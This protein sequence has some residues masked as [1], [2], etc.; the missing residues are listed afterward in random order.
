MRMPQVDWLGQKAQID[1]ARGAGVKKVVLISSMGVTDE[2]NPLN[3]LGDGN[4]LVWK[5]RAEVCTAHCAGPD[6]LH[7]RVQDHRKSC[8]PVGV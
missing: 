6:M 8:W 1:A 5:R 4:I 7:C 3:K 2:S